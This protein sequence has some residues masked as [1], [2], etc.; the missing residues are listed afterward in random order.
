MTRL[1][2]DQGLPRSSVQRLAD[3]GIDVCHVADIGYSR[4]TD[5]EI[6]TLA[7]EQER[8]VV[9]LDSDFHRLLVISGASKP[10]VIRIR[11]E[12]LRGP[13][14]A[15][16]IAQLLEQLR[17][18]LKAGAMVTVTERAVRLHRLPLRKVASKPSR[19]ERH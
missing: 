4:S 2:L 16:L 17:E 5:E 12:G 3:Q 6:M 13:E 14:A 7:L 8:T 15:M 11:R 18:Q 10:S 9:T 19:G 1:L